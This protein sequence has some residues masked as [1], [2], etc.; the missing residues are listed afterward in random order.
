MLLSRSFQNFGEWKAPTQ[1]LTELLVR[2]LEHGV[3]FEVN[4]VT[5]S[6]ARSFCKLHSGAIFGLAP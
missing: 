1:I 2:A 5:F 4:S 3:V 6:W